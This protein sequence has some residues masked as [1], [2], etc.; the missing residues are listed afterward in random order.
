MHNKQPSNCASSKSQSSHSCQCTLH[1]IS[2]NSL[3]LINGSASALESSVD[4]IQYNTN[5]QSA[6]VGGVYPQ[7][8]TVE[9]PQF[10]RTK[11]HPTDFNSDARKYSKR[12][13][14]NMSASL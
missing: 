10:H 1:Q 5:P 11:S 4:L 2:Q 3:P 8:N 7:T 14:L 9:D 12:R 13:P 6:F